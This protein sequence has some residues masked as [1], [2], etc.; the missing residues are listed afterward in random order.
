MRKWSRG[1]VLRAQTGLMVAF[2]ALAMFRGLIPGLCATL[3]EVDAP[4]AE[5]QI[6]AGCCSDAADTAPGSASESAHCASCSLLTTTAHS[7]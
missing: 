5:I 1:N 6:S 7:V 3:A 4:H 2:Y